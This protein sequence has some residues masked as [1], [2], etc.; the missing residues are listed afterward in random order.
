[1][2]LFVVF[3]IRAPSEAVLKNVAKNMNRADESV[4]LS[5]PWV[6]SLPTRAR[7][8]A[9]SQCGDCQ[10]RICKVAPRVLP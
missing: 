9:W 1:M 3:C 2:R 4:F 5:K 8:R 6:M 7:N 10:E